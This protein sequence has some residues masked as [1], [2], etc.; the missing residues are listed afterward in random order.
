VNTFKHRRFPLILLSLFFCANAVPQLVNPSGTT[1]LERFSLPGGYERIKYPDHSFQKF[2]RLFPLKPFNSPVYLHNGQIKGNAVH[3]S[4]FSMPILAQDLIQCADAVIKLR[5]EY[6]YQIKNYDEISF[7]ITN[8]MDVPFGKFT[9][10]FRVSI[11]GNSTAWKEGYKKG[12]SRDIFDE[13]LKFIY[14]YAGTYSLAQ[15]S[16]R[17]TID[18]IEVGDYFI[19][20]GNPGHV[21]MVVDLAK[22]KSTGNRIMLLGQ[23][24]MPSQEF[25]V[26]KSNTDI[27][28]WYYVRDE[29][30]VTPEW[31]FDRNSLMCF[32]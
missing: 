10:G 14:M 1:I 7:R 26:L 28:P 23:S 20:G 32:K 18:Q 17:K 8:G 6:L 22:D 21:V 19:F 16:R 11:T 4:V 25:H 3:I 9:E 30:L 13:Y 27:F 15:E 12:N 24:Y 31:T 5:A 29:K 2:L